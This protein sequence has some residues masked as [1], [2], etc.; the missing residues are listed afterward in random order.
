MI[1]MQVTQATGSGVASFACTSE[2]DL[3]SWGSSKRGQLGLGSGVLSCKNPTRLP[4]VKNIVQVSSG[5][6]HALALNGS[7]PHK[8]PVTNLSACHIGLG[9][10]SN[11]HAPEQTLAS[12]SLTSFAYAQLRHAKISKLYLHLV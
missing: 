8:R 12:F 2:G 1:R 7:L 3:Y 9:L 5:W 10:R 11:R 4:G 6:G